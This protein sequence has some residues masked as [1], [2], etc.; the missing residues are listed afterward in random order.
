[1]GLLD[2][3]EA[4]ANGGI[5]RGFQWINGSFVEDKEAR[6]SNPPCDID[7]LTFYYP[8]EQTDDSHMH[9]FNA[10]EMTTIYRVDAQGIVLGE[11]MTREI[12]EY[13]AYWQNQWTHR[14]DGTRK[15]MV[16][17]ELDSREDQPARARLESLME[18][19]GW[20]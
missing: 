7:V 2:Y 4:L 15:G 14:I 16:E 19:R 9:L 17:I 20:I 11:E 10:E 8:P 18:E 1:M 3:R 13:V 12:A 6:E 5:T